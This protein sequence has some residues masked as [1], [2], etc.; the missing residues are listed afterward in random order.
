LAEALGIDIE[1]REI[2]HNVAYNEA[3]LSFARANGKFLTLV[4]KSFAE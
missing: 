1:A 3:L 4:E 2:A